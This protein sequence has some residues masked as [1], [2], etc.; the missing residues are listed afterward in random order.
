MLLEPFDVEKILLAPS[1]TLVDDEMLMGEHSRLLVSEGGRDAARPGGSVRLRCELEAAP[2]S[3][4]RKRQLEGERQ[5]TLRLQD[6]S[7][8][9]RARRV[10]ALAILVGSARNRL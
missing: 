6:T 1:S 2:A 4:K 9:R 3:R 5:G 8:R 7:R 10:L